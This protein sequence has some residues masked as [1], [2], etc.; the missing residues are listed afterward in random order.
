M[1]RSRFERGGNLR[2]VPR[3]VGALA[4]ASIAS[5]GVRLLARNN[6][7]RPEHGG[8]RDLD[9]DQYDGT[10]EIDQRP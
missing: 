1:E 9:F 10:S 8:W 2:F 5:V 4:L 7:T 3:V 6:R